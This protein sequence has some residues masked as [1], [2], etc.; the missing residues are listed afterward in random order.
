MKLYATIIF[1]FLSA[2]FS[3]LAMETP[4]PRLLFYNQK[5]LKPPKPER[6]NILFIG[7]PGAGKSSL[8]NALMG[9][10]EFKSGTSMGCGLT[11]SLRI[12]K[13]GTIYYFDLPGLLECDDKRRDNNAA[14]I[15]KAFTEPGNFLVFFVLKQDDLRFTN[16]DLMTMKLVLES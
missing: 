11:E 1:L 16:Q 9:S 8:L 7:N 5:E 4:S 14:E 10:R 3:S 15:V 13:N 2:A 6:T 12:K